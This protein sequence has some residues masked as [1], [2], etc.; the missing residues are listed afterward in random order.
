ALGVTFQ[1]GERAEAVSRRGDALV[2]SMPSGVEIVADKVLGTA[3]RTGNTEGLGLEAVGVD[4]DERGRVLVD[5]HFATTVPG[6]FAAG[7]VIGAPALAS[8]SMEQARG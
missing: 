1:F 8:T 3:G 2:C 7:D 6:V 5:G 4:T